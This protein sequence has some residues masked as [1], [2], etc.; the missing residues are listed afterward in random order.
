MSSFPPSVRGADVQADADPSTVAADPRAVERSRYE[1][2]ALATLD[3]VVPGSGQV[4]AQRRRLDP[5]PASTCRFPL[6]DVL[7]AGVGVGE[8]A[9][10]GCRRTRPGPSTSV[11]WVTV[12]C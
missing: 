12:R 2:A 10:D 9:A 3:A 11:A 7:S 8:H 4:L 1:R 5:Q 6:L